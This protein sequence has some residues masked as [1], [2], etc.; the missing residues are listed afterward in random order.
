M[1][2]RFEEEGYAEQKD[3]HFRLIDLTWEE[4]YTMG[5]PG[6]LDDKNEEEYKI[7]FLRI[8][9]CLVTGYKN[10]LV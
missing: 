8:F 2:N 7:Y 1:F 3:N 10:F 6:I 4:L 9:L 5:V